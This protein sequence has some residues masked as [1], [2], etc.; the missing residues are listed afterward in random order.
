MTLLFP[1]TRRARAV[2]ALAVTVGTAGSAGAQNSQPP[3]TIPGL[4][5]FSLPT[6]PPRP[7]P[8]PTPEPKV[9]PLPRPTPSA[10][11]TPSATPTPATVTPPPVRP[12]VRAT[13]TPRATPA[14]TPTPIARATV[15]APALTPA[16]APTAIPT[17]APAPEASPPAAVVAATPP[18]APAAK[19]WGSL[20]LWAAGVSLIAVCAGVVLYRR[21]R[22]GDDEITAEAEPATA[23][24]PPPAPSPPAPAPVA[25]AVAA[26]RARIAIALEV[27]RA[28]TNLLS[29]AV[30]Y[31]IVLHNAGEVDARAIA[32]DLRLFGVEP[33][34]ERTLDA[35]FAAP[36]ERAVVARFDLAAGATAALEGTA[37]LP[38]DVMPP[39][40][41]QGV[42]EGRALFV[43]V[44]T[45][46]LDYAWE[47]GHG[48]SAASFVVGLDRG[49]DAKLGPF[50][51]DG[52]PRM[53]DRV[54]HLS[55]TVSRDD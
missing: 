51:L 26:P 13:P 8:V 40:A 31:R 47:G 27:K 16:R 37:M 20:G 34:L 4:E 41:I 54:R 14:A 36:I 1:A 17:S 29:A 38:R 45:V 35:L 44:M 5:G 11:A 32:L 48:R 30:E 55:F 21:R 22:R 7:T 3:A 12:T 24:P 39:L 18:S 49:A 15:P 53:H 25:E 43:P 42:G 50:R 28:G 6:E 33:G 46:A 10:T 19:N 23:P 52:P 2:L 9:A